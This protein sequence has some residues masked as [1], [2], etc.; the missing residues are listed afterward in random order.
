MRPYVSARSTRVGRRRSVCHSIAR[1]SRSSRSTSIVGRRSSVDEDGG[2][3]GRGERGGEGR[4]RRWRWRERSRRGSRAASAREG[5]RREANGGRTG[6]RAR[7]RRMGTRTMDDDDEDA[8]DVECRC[9]IDWGRRINRRL[10][11]AEAAGRSSDEGKIPRRDAT[12]AIVDFDGMTS[13]VSASTVSRRA[14][15]ASRR[16]RPRAAETRGVRRGEAR[17]RRRRGARVR[18]RDHPS[19]RH[20]RG[21]LAPPRGRGVGGAAVRHRGVER[22]QLVFKQIRVHRERVAG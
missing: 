3:G 13:T 16:A 22:V 21:L 17:G 9:W 6:R 11:L 14:A 1:A 15:R 19:L 7:W 20:G 4:R 18:R 2:H 8:V 10:R 5:A 12:V